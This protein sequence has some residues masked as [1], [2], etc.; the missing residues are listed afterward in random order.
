MSKIAVMYLLS[1][2]R[3]KQKDREEA[4]MRVEQMAAA[5]GKGSPA[6]F[7]AASNTQHVYKAPLARRKL[8]A[9]LWRVETMN[10]DPI[11]NAI[12]DVLKGDGGDDDT[13]LKEMVGL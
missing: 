7:M 12:D 11:E 13:L 6:A 4:W 10:M 2:E 9:I 5:N 1:R 3:K 8:N